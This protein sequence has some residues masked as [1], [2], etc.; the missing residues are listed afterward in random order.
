M[1]TAATA[2]GP[3]G[4]LL[5]IDGHPAM[6]SLDDHGGSGALIVR[7]PYA[8]A[9]P[10]VEDARGQ[11]SYA[12]P[13][14]QLQASCTIGFAH[15]SSAI[16]NAAIGAGFI[17]RQFEE[18]DRIPWDARLP[19]LAKV[20]IIRRYRKKCRSFRSLSSS[21]RNAAKSA[22]GRVDYLL[23]IARSNASRMKR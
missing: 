12:A 10:I 3:G 4:R 2:L 9:E 20:S 17:I 16:L 13:Q 1:Q 15:G 6:Y 19:Q 23:L 8:S 21:K 5:L 18:L 7:H 11:G 14:A 22:C